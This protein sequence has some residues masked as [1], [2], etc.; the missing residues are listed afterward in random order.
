MQFKTSIVIAALLFS[1][2]C[3]VIPTVQ[4]RA[5]QSEADLDGLT[6]SFY[7]DSTEIQ[8]S[9]AAS[10]IAVKDEKGTDLQDSQ[11][12]YSIVARRT[13]YIG[14]KLGI[15]AIKNWRSSTLISI[16]KVD[17]TDLVKSIG[18]E[19]SNEVVKSIN[20]LGGVV[21]S[22]I[23]STA[24]DEAGKAEPCM[25][26]GSS[27]TISLPEDLDKPIV[28][29]NSETPCVEIVIDALPV[30]AIKATDIPLSKDSN[31]YYY[32]ACRDATV[33]IKSGGGEV[34]TGRVRIAD[35]RY[36]QKVQFPVKGTLSMHSNC[37]V[38]V[39]TDAHATNE[40]PAI[41]DALVAQAKA[42][43]DAVE[44]SKKD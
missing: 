20:A 23:K 37:G 9:R 25:K 6:D 44:A 40:G 38:S 39:K 10:R 4:Y 41:I 13:P 32:S 7:R 12:D 21:V 31:H 18:V 11:R 14:Q 42:I 30:D 36:L 28:K 16:N 29:P 33:N 8:V 24:L 22:V 17:N 27:I 1:T 34:T 26:A 43:S 35:P 19:V 2:G 5:I 3:T 15:K